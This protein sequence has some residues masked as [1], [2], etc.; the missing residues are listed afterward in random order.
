[1]KRDT[2][3]D[4]KEI[5]ED[6]SFTPRV[7]EVFDDMLRR[8]VPCYGQIIE[9]AAQILQ[10]FLEDGDTIYDLGCS[11]GT[12][13]LT[14]AAKLGDK[15]LN[16]V[17]LDNSPAMIAKASQK[18]AMYRAKERLRFQEG[19][20]LQEELGPAG[21]VIMNYTMQFIRPLQRQTLLERIYN[22]LR[23]GGILIVSEKIVSTN[24]VLNRSFIRFYLD[25]KRS[26]GYSEIEIAKKREALENVLVPFSARENL[27]M[28]HKAGFTTA[29]PFFQW[30]NFISIAAIKE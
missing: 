11:T 19:D 23:P 29:E 14:L 4:T 30:Y 28:L 8:S 15:S 6:F 10:D 24:P 20:I 16:F 9:M 1:V 13:L 2:I 5:S 3:F 17:G 7:A 26:Q 21:A 22:S 12:T 25:F 18:A 27:A